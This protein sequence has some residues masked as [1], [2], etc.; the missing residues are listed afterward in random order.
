MAAYATAKET[1]DC[2]QDIDGN[3]TNPYDGIGQN[4]SFAMQFLDLFGNEMP[5]SQ[6][7]SLKDVPNNY[8]D[9]ILGI[10]G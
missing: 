8:F 7:T 9:Q 5:T 1:N 4:A 3:I 10:D 6:D 2:S